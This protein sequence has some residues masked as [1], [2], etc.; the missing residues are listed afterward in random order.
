MQQTFLTFYKLDT[1]PTFYN[2]T[3]GEYCIFSAS[4]LKPC[5]NGVYMK[6]FCQAFDENCQKVKKMKLHKGSVIDMTCDM[7][8]YVKDGQ[9]HLSYIV[10]SLRFSEFY[11]KPEP[12]VQTQAKQQPQNRL[13]EAA[14]MLDNNPFA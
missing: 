2:S 14:I 4:S 1:A 6:I 3:N 9:P 8:P 11:E 12:V 10:M 13:M 5:R 7:V